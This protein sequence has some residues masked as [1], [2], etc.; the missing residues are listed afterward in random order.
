MIAFIQRLLGYGLTGDVS[1]RILPIFY[2]GGANGKSTL[3]NTYMAVLGDDYARPASASLLMYKRNE[4]HPTEIAS[5]FGKRFVTCI[6][7][8]DG[9]KL[10]EELLKQLTGNDRLSARRMR[11]DFWDF[12]P[13]HKLVVATNHKPQVFGQDDAI[14][15][16]IRLIP[17]N[18]RFTEDQ[19]D[20]ELPQKLRAE[21]TGILA[22][23]VTGCVAWAKD[24]LQTPPQVRAATSQ[25]RAE[26]DRIGEFIEEECVG[27][28]TEK[29]GRLHARYADWSRVRGEIPL[30]N[31]RFGQALERFGY[32]KH[33][34]DGV[35]VY[36]AISLRR[37]QGVTVVP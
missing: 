23:A 12:N 14:W 20:K 30:G 6:E 32:E 9:G 31:K 16:R 28:G 15:D 36:R 37:Q 5:L 34:S 21:A 4:S 19:R 18:V 26:E 3:L 27:E 22:W 35:M 24:G 17:F 11:E 7:T 8:K 33:K 1:E 29:L 13:T 2:G 10:N 25:Y